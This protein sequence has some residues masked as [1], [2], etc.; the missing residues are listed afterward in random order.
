M[1]IYIKFG[2]RTCLCH[3]GILQFKL[4]NM[5]NYLVPVFILILVFISFLS[6]E[7]KWAKNII[8]YTCTY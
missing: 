6:F 2:K 8:I 7:N 5:S 4:K 3:C 1:C